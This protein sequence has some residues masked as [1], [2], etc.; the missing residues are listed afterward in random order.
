MRANATAKGT[1]RLGKYQRTKGHNYERAIANVFRT[2]YPEDSVSRGHQ[3]HRP[4]RPDVV[5][6]TGMYGPRLW[7]ECKVGARPNIHA[8]FAQATRDS[9]RDATRDDWIRLAVTKRDREKDLVTMSLDDFMEILRA[10][11][12]L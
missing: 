6:M 7:V 12:R 2:L 11:E 9:A 1:D 4:D 10:V 5:I 3:T 8:A